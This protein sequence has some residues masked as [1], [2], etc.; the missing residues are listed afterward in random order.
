[1]MAR[2]L[3]T[4]AIL[5]ACLPTQNLLAAEN[6]PDLRG[7]PTIVYSFDFPRMVYGHHQISSK[8]RRLCRLSSDGWESVPASISPPV[9]Y[10]TLTPRGPFIAEEEE[11]RLGFAP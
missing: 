7:I 2:N 6:L 3:A 1:M 9:N 11:A 8:V 5:L 10:M 4:L